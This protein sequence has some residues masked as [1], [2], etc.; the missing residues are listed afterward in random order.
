MF[1]NTPKDKN[2]LS[3]SERITLKKLAFKSNSQGIDVNYVA[4]KIAILTSLSKISY[5]F[6][7][8]LQRSSE[9]E[10]GNLLMYT[11]CEICYTS[12]TFFATKFIAKNFV[13]GYYEYSRGHYKDNADWGYNQMRDKILEIEDDRFQA[14]KKF[15]SVLKKTLGDSRYPFAFIS[16]EKSLEETQKLRRE[17][18]EEAF[19][20]H[21]FGESYAFAMDCQEIHRDKPFLI[22]L[23]IPIFEITDELIFF[24][25]KN[26]E[27]SLIK[28]SLEEAKTH[29][30]QH[31][32]LV[33]IKIGNP[34]LLF[35]K[36]IGFDVFLEDLKK[37]VREQKKYMPN[38]KNQSS[39]KDSDDIY[40]VAQLEE[41]LLTTN[42]VKD[43]NLEKSIKENFDT[44]VEALQQQ[45]F[46]DVLNLKLAN[47]VKTDS[48]YHLKFDFPDEEICMIFRSNL[49][50]FGSCLKIEDEE[51]EETSRR[52]TGI[53][54]KAVDKKSITLTLT[55]TKPDLDQ[56]K[57]AFVEIKTQINRKKIKDLDRSN[58]QLVAQLL[59]IDE[60]DV[61]LVILKGLR[62]NNDKIREL[63]DTSL[64]QP[65]NNFVSA[66]PNLALCLSAGKDNQFEFSPE[67][68][69]KLK[70]K[71]MGILDDKKLFIIQE[72]EDV[73]RVKFNKNVAFR[74]DFSIRDYALEKL[75]S[76]EDA[77]KKI[78]MEQE[79]LVEVSENSHSEL[80][81]PNPELKALTIWGANSSV[82]ENREILEAVNINVRFYVQ[83]S[84]TLSSIKSLKQLCSITDFSFGILNE[85]EFDKTTH[86]ERE[87]EL[88]GIFHYKID[89]L[90]KKITTDPQNPLP[91]ETAERA[92][93]LIYFLLNY[94][95][96]DSEA[97]AKDIYY[98]QERG[99]FKGYHHGLGHA[100]GNNVQQ[101][102]KLVITLDR[103]AEF[104]DDREKLSL[105]KLEEYHIEIIK[106]QDRE[107][108]IVEKTAEDLVGNLCNLLKRYPLTDTLKFAKDRICQLVFPELK[109]KDISTQEF[110]EKKAKII[111]EL[112]QNPEKFDKL[113]QQFAE[114]F[115][116][117]K[118]L[119]EIGVGR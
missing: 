39:Q 28:K 62:Q 115:F 119:R 102:K 20:N 2:S 90:A 85:I 79:L 97:V 50:K 86:P 6:I 112:E 60:S 59:E 107:L 110:I 31:K 7:L 75:K 64:L 96:G 4:K 1:Q 61:I 12:L 25:K 82:L 15:C 67:F 87:K 33:E 73:V 46:S 88:K 54:T 63:L 11:G 74:S 40:R 104:S 76:L 5:F 3:K 66:F 16:D 29:G 81:D 116:Q 13:S 38:V 101:L 55:Q 103:L 71:N 22:K 84:S 47:Q 69:E 18:I 49:V 70:E 17:K 109:S 30:E 44:F 14:T 94:S 92:K 26:K 65:K 10:Q 34:D 35:D 37:I 56:L 77:V 114:R 9:A 99:D 27:F 42:S 108:Q 83:K 8:N 45:D 52:R 105:E 41:H 111:K 118:G 100:S 68:F 23:E 93:S 51:I 19:K 72:D 21:L 80:K 24:L 91:Q 43:E 106:T 53:V 57:E 89:E 32:L 36:A 78:Q 95:S 113:K 117:G 48:K 58:D 98:L